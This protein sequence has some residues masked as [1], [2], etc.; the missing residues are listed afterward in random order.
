MARRRFGPAWVRGC[1]VADVH[2]GTAG[3]S[4]D[5]ARGKGP[6]MMS[7]RTALGALAAPLLAPRAVHGRASALAQPAAGRQ[8]GAGQAVVH[9]APRPL[10]ADAL[11]HDW[12]SFLGPTHNGVSTETRLSRPCRRRWSGSCPPVPATPR[13]RSTAIGS[14]TCTGSATKR[15][16]SA[17]TRRPA[18]PTGACGIRRRTAIATGTT[19]AR[20]RVP[21]STPPAAGSARWAPRGA[22]TPWSWIPVASSGDRTCE[23]RTTCG[24]TSSASARRRS[25][26]AAC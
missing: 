4:S 25:S 17:C 23:R 5:V 22:S 11:T 8:A 18:P 20:A 16:S 7:R 19:T 26:R 24:R 21:S 6:R 13:R 1:D 12:T 9:R 10:A 2:D 14:S 15:S 3:A